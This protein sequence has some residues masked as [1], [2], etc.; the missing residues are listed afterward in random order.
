[1]FYVGANGREVYENKRPVSEAQL[2]GIRSRFEERRDWLAERGIKLYIIFPRVA[3]FIYEEKLGPRMFRHHEQSK[4][5]QVVDYLERNSDLNI[6][7]V[8]KPLLDAKD[9]SKPE[10]YYKKATHWNYYGAYFAYAALID[11]IRKDFP[12]VGPRIPLEEIKWLQYPE[13]K[14]DMDL[15]QMSALVGY[16]MGQ[17]IKP[18]HPRLYAGDTIAYCPQRSRDD[19]PALYAEDPQGRGPDMLMFHDSYAKYLYPYLGTHF[20]RSSYFWTPT[21][22]TLLIEEGK[23]KLVIWEISERFIPFY[24]LYKNRPFADEGDK[25]KVNAPFITLNRYY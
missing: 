19:F 3:H 15:I 16:V 18:V 13:P 10:L 9:P 8:G 22:N 11:S 14:K 24:F 5:E 23:P 2:A 20:H 4:L 25:S 1:M 17:E 21:F 7:D 12:E 6:I